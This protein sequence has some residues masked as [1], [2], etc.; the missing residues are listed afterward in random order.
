M[1]VGEQPGDEEDLK[2]RPFV[3][4]AGRLL[5]QLL[6]EAGIDRKIGVRHQRGQTFQMGAARQA[7]HP[8][9]ARAAGSGRLRSL[10]AR[11]ARAVATRASSS[12]SARPH[13]ARCPRVAGPVGKSRGETV[14]V[15]TKACRWWPRGIRRR[16]CARVT[17]ASK[18]CAPRSCRICVA[19]RHSLPTTGARFSQDSALLEPEQLA[20]VFVADRIELRIGQ[21]KPFERV[22]RLRDR[23]LRVV[24]PE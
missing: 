20:R 14:G 17:I 19:P 2:G 8:Q 22:Q 7:P 21:S 10:V 13:C 9:D 5:D 11:R 16:C 1:L 18:G 23:D 12:R 24:R 6:E 4:P 15:R 3:G